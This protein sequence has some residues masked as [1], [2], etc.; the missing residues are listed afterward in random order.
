MTARAQ[1]IALGA[2]AES[3]RIVAVAA[4]H[5]LAVHP[6]LDEGAVHVDLGLDLTVGVIQVFAQQLRLEVVQKRTTDSWLGAHRVAA[7]VAA[8]AGLDLPA[9]VAP[10]ELHRQAVVGRTRLGAGCP[11]QVRAGRPVAGLAAHVDLGPGR[12]VRVRL[13]VV[14]LAQIGGVTL[15]AHAVPALVASGPVQGIV[16]GDALVGIEVEPALSLGVPREGQALDAAAGE[17]DQVLLERLDAERVPHLE[18]AH[19]AVRRLGV[20]EE[21]PVLPEEARHDWK[22]GEAR[23]VEIAEHCVFAGNLHRSVVMRARPRFERVSVA[24]DAGGASDECHGGARRRRVTSPARQHGHRR[25]RA[26]RPP[27]RSRRG[28]GSRG[29]PFSRMQRSTASS[30][31]ARSSVGSEDSGRMPFTRSRSLR[32]ILRFTIAALLDS[33]PPSPRPTAGS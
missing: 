13:D 32:S 5:A 20:D 33:G 7:G 23:I 1:R 27:D 4:A 28:Y 15:G 29:Q 18:V 21:L 10:R 17:L 22:A 26:E 3:V 2:D 11:R 8:R 16:R 6:A 24:L 9:R 19:G 25:A 30:I 14:A 31:A 12:A